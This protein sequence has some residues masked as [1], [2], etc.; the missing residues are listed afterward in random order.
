MHDRGGAQFFYELPVCAGKRYRSSVKNLDSRSFSGIRRFLGR[1]TL[2]A[3]GVMA[4]STMVP[5]ATHHIFGCNR[6]LSIGVGT[7]SSAN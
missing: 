2:C 5:L 6:L 7:S 4:K 3:H 1:Y